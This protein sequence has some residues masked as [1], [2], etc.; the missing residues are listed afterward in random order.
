ME[1]MMDGV[2]LPRFDREVFM[3]RAG[4]KSTRCY[5]RGARLSMNLET[6]GVLMWSAPTRRR[7]VSATEE[8]GG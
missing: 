5:R 2:R 6:R 3:V 7:S 4:A 1:L 8:S